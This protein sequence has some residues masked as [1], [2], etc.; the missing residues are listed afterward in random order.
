MSAMFIV[1]STGNWTEKK[2]YNNWD[3][4]TPEKFDAFWFDEKNTQFLYHA[5]NYVI[6]KDQIA[7]AR[8]RLT[9]EVQIYT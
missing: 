4:P 1:F 3:F 9:P 8:I 5:L 7:I 6:G 2:I